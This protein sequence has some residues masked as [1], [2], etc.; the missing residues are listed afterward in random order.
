MINSPILGGE[1]SYKTNFTSL[2]RD[3]AA[4]IRSPRWPIQG[5]CL[6]ASADPLARMPA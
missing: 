1:F 2:T 6:N 3:T 4:S 5:L